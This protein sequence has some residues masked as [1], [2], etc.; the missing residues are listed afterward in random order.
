[1]P[2]NEGDELDFVSKCDTVQHIGQIISNPK[3]N[4]SPHFVDK[5]LLAA[6]DLGFQVR[7]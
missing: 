3:L 7:K 6:S 5:N 4:Q 1:M 2:I